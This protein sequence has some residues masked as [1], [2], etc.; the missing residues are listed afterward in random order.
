M[1]GGR[2]DTVGCLLENDGAGVVRIAGLVG[3]R[4]SILDETADTSSMI[5]LAE[6]QYLEINWWMTFTE[7]DFQRLC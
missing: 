7:Y 6:K 3:P 5:A 2:E 4:A 1:A